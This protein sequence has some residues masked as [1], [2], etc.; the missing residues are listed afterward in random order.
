VRDSARKAGALAAVSLI[1]TLSF[2]A[3]VAMMLVESESGVSVVGAIHGFLFLAYAFLVFR[4][5]KTFG[6]TTNFMLLAIVTGPIGAV[7][8]L[9]RLRREGL[10]MKA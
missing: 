10:L 2:L 8:V 7:V 6:W 9:E 3:L 5:H 4:D 1:E